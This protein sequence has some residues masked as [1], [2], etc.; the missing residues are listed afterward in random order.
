VADWAF[1][2]IC[3]QTKGQRTVALAAVIFQ[4]C[5]LGYTL[6]QVA[7]ADVVVLANNPAAQA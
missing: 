2:R 3:H 1:H 7:R 5:S 4:P 6:V